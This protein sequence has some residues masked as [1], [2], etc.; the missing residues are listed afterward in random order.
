[1]KGTLPKLSINNTHTKSK[2]TDKDQ[3]K[4]KKTFETDVILQRKLLFYLIIGLLSFFFVSFGRIGFF[5]LFPGP[6]ILSTV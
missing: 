1:M 3:K 6:S 4:E 2:D 5:L